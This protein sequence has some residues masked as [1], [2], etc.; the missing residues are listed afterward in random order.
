[1]RRRPAAF[2]VR[3][4][5]SVWLAL[6]LTTASALAF[7]GVSGNLDTFSTALGTLHATLQPAAD[8]G[9]KSENYRRDVYAVLMAIGAVREDNGKPGVSAIKP[10]KHAAAQAIIAALTIALAEFDSDD[11]ADA[12]AVAICHAHSIPFHGVREAA[13]RA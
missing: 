12:L 5:V 7:I 8:K 10:E 3:P 11:A 6:L 4:V 1:M 13:A 9:D 2:A